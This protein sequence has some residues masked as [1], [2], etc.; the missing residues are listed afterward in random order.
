MLQFALLIVIGL[1]VGLF[2]ISMGGGGGAIYLG[3]LT[4]VFNLAPASAAAT[5]IITALPSL[6]IGC[7]LYYRQGQ[8]NFHLGNTMLISAIPSVIIGALI[9]P[10]IPT[11]L[12]NLIIGLILFILG[13]QV[14]YKLRTSSQ[15]QEAHSSKLLPLIF[16]AIS[17][18]MVGVA[19]LSGGGPIMAGLLV[20]GASMIQASATSSYVLICMSVIGAITHLSGGQIDWSVG[21][22]LMCGAIIGAAIAPKLM[23]KVA[24]GRGAV[25][26]KI[27]MGVLLIFMGLKT[28]L[29]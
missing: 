24:V 10:F 7:W 13:V 4:A 5:S 8:I 26:L 1:F 9:A 6:A 27:I 19:G 14:L 12:Y 2:V 20:M 15:P 18:L 16:G 17:G 3:V 11:K 23:K 28:F 22:S 21:I 29:N 25:I